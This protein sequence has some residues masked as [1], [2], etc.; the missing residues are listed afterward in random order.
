VLELAG[1]PAEVVLEDEGFNPGT[2]WRPPTPSSSKA[3]KSKEEQV[4][5]RV[6]GIVR[7]K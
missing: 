1:A 5:G 3:V 7:R 6:V 2:P 4:A